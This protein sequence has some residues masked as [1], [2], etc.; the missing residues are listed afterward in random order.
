[1]SKEIV[2]LKRECEATEIPSGRKMTFFSGTEV[3][4]LQ[5]LGGSYTVMTH[6]G[7]MASIAGKD[8]DALGKEPMADPAPLAA[9]EAPTTEKLVWAQLKT[10]YD[11]EIPHNIVDL[12]LVYDCKVTPLE[13]TNSKVDIKMTLTAPG[14]GM[15]E[16]LRQD[17]Q[18][19]VQTVPGIKECNVEVVFDPP[20]DR[21][22]M[23]PAL[24]REL[25]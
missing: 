15:G 20:W 13:E 12:G 10:C 8:S 22:M 9:G 25:G 7:Q 3:I 4:I 14:C 16:W 23:H 11:P 5:T 18:K 19:K 24:R 21:S 17:V 1:M 6:M 2:A